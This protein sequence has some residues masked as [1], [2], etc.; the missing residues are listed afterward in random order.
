M[1]FPLSRLEVVGIKLQALGDNGRL[2]LLSTPN[3]NIVQSG[4]QAPVS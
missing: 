4:H 2:H 1:I 3:P